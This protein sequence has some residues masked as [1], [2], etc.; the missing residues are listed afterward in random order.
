MKC[1]QYLCNRAH[2]HDSYDY[3]CYNMLVIIVQNY[4]IVFRQPISLR[5]LK[6]SAACCRLDVTR[7]IFICSQTV[8]LTGSIPSINSGT[9]PSLSA[10]S[11]H[12]KLLQNVSC[13]L[14]HVLPDLNNW[15]LIL[16]TLLLFT[17]RT[18]T[19]S[20]SQGSCY[21]I[22]YVLVVPKWQGI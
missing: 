8:S 17:Y 2:P 21:G 13:N 6:A 16:I 20:L 1:Q 7:N 15:I 18:A 11:V 19:W 22:K 3:F 9:L 14:P 5:S 4:F 10:C 12:R